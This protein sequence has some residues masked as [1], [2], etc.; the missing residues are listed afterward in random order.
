MAKESLLSISEACHMLGVS[1]ASLRQWTD[2]GKIK[3]FITPGGH[4]RYVKEDL[5]KFISLHNKTFGIKDL[6][7]ELEGTVYLHREIAR[8]SLNRT[9]WYNEL[10]EESQEYLALLSRRILGLII[11]YITEPSKRE[12]TIIQ[13]RDVGHGFGEI[14]A[15]IELPLADAVEA[16]L[17]HRD[18]IL[19]TTT[20]LLKKREAFTW[21]VLDA[22]PLV[23]HI[24]D[25]ALISLVATHQQYQD[26]H[27]RFK[28]GN[29]D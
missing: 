15:K 26:S 7:V 2:K 23:T 10:S 16:F 1:E 11:R 28:G 9:S 6:V 4:R 24:F 29:A 17:L 14:L 12:E 5:K 19:N 21:R 25:E 27:S 18:P 3:A 13:A 8:T 20:H 22:I